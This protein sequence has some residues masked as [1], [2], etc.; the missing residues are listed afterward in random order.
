MTFVI[1]RCVTPLQQLQVPG[2]GWPQAAAPQLAVLFV[3]DGMSL[4]DMYRSSASRFARNFQC[5]CGSQG[6]LILNT[7]MCHRRSEPW[8]GELEKQA[9][10]ASI[11]I[12]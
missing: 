7:Y 9:S 8:Q 3:K 6:S 4:T 10:K 5:I 2:G 12:V 11:R 1:E